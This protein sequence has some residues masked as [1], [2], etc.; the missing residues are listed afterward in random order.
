MLPD[1]GEGRVGRDRLWPVFLLSL[2]LRLQDVT[3]AE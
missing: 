2:L 1:A 3:G